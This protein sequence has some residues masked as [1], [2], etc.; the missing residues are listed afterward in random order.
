MY[1]QHGFTNE[2]I[3]DEYLD[4]Q[5]GV[6]DAKFTTVDTVIANASLSGN[7]LGGILLA[8]SIT[9]LIS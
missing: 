8:L 2:Q 6:M 4:G 5:N 3:I 1:S 9:L 7:I